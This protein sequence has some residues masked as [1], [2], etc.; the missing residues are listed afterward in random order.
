VAKSELLKKDAVLRPVQGALNYNSGKG[1]QT[2]RTLFGREPQLIRRGISSEQF[3][4]RK[5]LR[6]QQNPGD[7]TSG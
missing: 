4:A 2:V 5:S 1:R 6:S 7:S 3:P